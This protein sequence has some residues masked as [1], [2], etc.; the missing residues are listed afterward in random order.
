MVF[1]LDQF[2]TLC[3]A[4]W[5]IKLNF[6]I[7]SF[8]FPITDNAFVVANIR[9]VVLISGYVKHVNVLDGF[10]LSKNCNSRI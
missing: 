9:T 3:F 2:S 4:N 7:F 1:R 6:H 5:L 10:R 8:L